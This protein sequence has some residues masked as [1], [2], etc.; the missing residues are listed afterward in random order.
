MEGPRP[1][2]LGE[3]C[4]KGYHGLRSASKWFCEIYRDKAVIVGLIKDVVRCSPAQ[5]MYKETEWTVVWG[6]SRWGF[7]LHNGQL[8]GFFAHLK[9]GHLHGGHAGLQHPADGMASHTDDLDFIGHADSLF[10]QST[11]NA[12]TL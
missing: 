4:D 5:S 7:N 9:G 2:N 10:F 12:K 1:D 3:S 11:K 6:L 8:G